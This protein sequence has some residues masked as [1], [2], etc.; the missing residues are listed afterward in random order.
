MNRTRSRSSLPQQG[1]GAP[2][3]SMT[4]KGGVVRIE[5]SM[6]PGTSGVELTDLACRT[7]SGFFAAYRETHGLDGSGDYFDPSLDPK[8]VFVG[9]G[10]EGVTVDVLPEHA[11]R[12]AACIAVFITDPVN[13]DPVNCGDSFVATFRGSFATARVRKWTQT[14][15][16]ALLER[17]RAEVV[18]MY[19]ALVPAPLDQF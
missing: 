14:D 11:E 6:C 12:I 1:T 16:A 15:A 13:H 2:W 5:A 8:K 9:V 3:V 18:A 19:P 7:L 10:W 17:V 4:P